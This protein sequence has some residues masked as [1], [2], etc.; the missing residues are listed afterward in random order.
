MSEP[1]VE[2]SALN[3]IPG[4]SEKRLEDDHMERYRFVVPHVRGLKGLDIACGPGYGTHMLSEAG[5]SM[6]GADLSAKI[7]E[8]ARKKYADSGI[9]FTE[10]DITT[11]RGGAPFD[12]IT[13]FETIEHLR[14]YREALANLFSLLKP[15][16]TLYISSPNR[17]VTTPEA[18]SLSD[19]PRNQHHTQEF[20]PDELVS[21]LREAGFSVADDSVFGQRYQVHFRTSWLRKLYRM[22][23]RPELRAS[24]ALRP[25]GRLTPRYFTIVAKKPG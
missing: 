21:F 18:K 23:F 2:L 1:A 16:G 20:T 12:F 14:P 4:E 10:G 15:G 13:C 8:Y 9:R 24:P 25:L 17:P 19:A 5:A 22:A 7:L 11:F 3:F 6:E